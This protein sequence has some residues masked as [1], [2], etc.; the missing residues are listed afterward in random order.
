MDDEK[1]ANI[2]SNQCGAECCKGVIFLGKQDIERLEKLGH[3]EFISNNGNSKLMETDEN[4]RC[5]FLN[6]N[7]KCSIYVDRPIDC[8]LF[9][10]GF[11]IRTDKIDIVLVK[12]PLSEVMSEET[13]TSMTKKAKRLI[14]SYSEDE[15][16]QYDNLPFESE[17]TVLNSFP[18]DEVI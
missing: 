18:T 4:N 15:L 5:V 11:K 12:C 2:C 17:Y 7:N 10:L 3:K 9:P 8:Q 1:V 6:E 16:R 13:I 14:S